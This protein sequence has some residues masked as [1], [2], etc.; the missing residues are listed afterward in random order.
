M[1]VQIPS[2]SPEPSSQSFLERHN[3][4]PVVF[5]ILV[6]VGLFFLYQVVGGI[7]AFLVMGG[8]SQL[9]RSNVN[10]IRSMTMGAQILFLFVPTLVAG[11][12]LS[13][14]VRR[15]FPYHPP[16]IRESLYSV[17]ALLSLQRVFDGYLFFQNLIPFPESLSKLVDPFKKMIEEMVRTL[18]KAES[19][20]E[21]F[22]VLLVVALV[23]AVVEEMLF[24]GFVISS[25][26]KKMLP[27]RAALLSGI[28]FGLFHLNP[29]E[30]VPLVGLGI[31][32][33]VLRVASDSM[34]LPIA[35]HFLNNFMAVVAVY[36]G[37]DQMPELNP[38]EV[39]RQTI[40]S[41]GFQFAM[42]SG[43]FA[44]ST[45]FYLRAARE[46]KIDRG[47]GI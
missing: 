21:L 9:D 8:G 6:L 18:V 30:V 40:L 44:Y 23:P 28:I 14:N 47:E 46:H 37:L 24:R 29:F 38:T 16:T 11:K 27:V 7:I 17:V 43:I 41:M 45:I 34:F 4:N 5:A 15:T 39:T 25:F 1:S 13:T 3:L 19:V 20:P 32:L 36:W 2:D 31:F 22:F 12:L 33:G 35:A 42:F 10:A 26:S